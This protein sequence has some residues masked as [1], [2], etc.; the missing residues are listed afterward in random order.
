[1]DSDT[2]QTKEKLILAG[3]RLFSDYGYDATTTRMIAKEA[4]VSLSAISFYFENKDALYNDCLE[5]IAEKATSYY[6]DAFKKAETLL[7]R[8]NV[9]IDEAYDMIS[10]LLRLQIETVFGKQYTSSLKLIY[11]EQISRPESYHPIT[12]AIFEY[13]EK[14]IARLIA[15]ST[16]MEY[17]DAI[18]ASRFINGSIIA[19]GE[20]TLLVQYALSDSK[21][22][23]VEPQEWVHEQIL[24]YSDLFVKDILGIKD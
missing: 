20:H 8:G 21:S 4:N 2:K 11:W 5:F 23:S 22:A 12:N 9:T 14:V 10:E 13:V 7:E 3:I 16:G 15:A 6:S 18:I 24:H 1:M 19:F 17:K